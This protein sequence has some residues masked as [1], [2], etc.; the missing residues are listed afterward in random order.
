MPVKERKDVT[1]EVMLYEFYSLDSL[2]CLIDMLSQL[3]LSLQKIL[4]KNDPLYEKQL[5]IYRFE[6]VIRYCELAESLGGLILGYSNLNIS[7]NKEV[8]K[9]HTKTT[10]IIYTKL[11]H[12]Y[13]EDVLK[14]YYFSYILEIHLLS[15]YF[16]Y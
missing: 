6:N 15:L 1:D 8:N 5:L 7:S 12:C 13:F 14:N 16:W 2:K 4:P 11:Y 10:L 3:N 9:D